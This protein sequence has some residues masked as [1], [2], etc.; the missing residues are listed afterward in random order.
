MYKCFDKQVPVYSIF[1]DIVS[2]YDNVQYDILLF[3]LKQYYGIYGNILLVIRD[4]FKDCWTRTVVN[5]VGS[6]WILPICG[7]GQG[8]PASPIFNLLYIDPLH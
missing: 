3:R 2:C 5:N 4:I 7:L 1:F 8:R 6:N